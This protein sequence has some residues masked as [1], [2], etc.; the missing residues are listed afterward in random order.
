MPTEDQIILVDIGDVQIGTMGK[1]ETHEKGLLHRAFS[2]FVRNDAGEILLQKRALGKYHSGGLWTNTCCG[3]PRDGEELTQ[4]VHRRLQ[5]EMGFDCPLAEIATLTYKVDLDRGLTEN[6]F[7]H[8]FVGEYTNDPTVNSEEAS[9][10]RWT[11]LA[12]IRSD[13]AEHP[14]NYT[15]WFKIILKRVEEEHILLT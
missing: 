15:H 4:A 8:I 2:I 12:D 1:L 3:H 9:D 5:E 6:E 14:E 10:W 7:L 11:T 13:V